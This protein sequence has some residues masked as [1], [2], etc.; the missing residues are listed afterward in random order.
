MSVQKVELGRALTAADP[1]PILSYRGVKH[2]LGTSGQQIEDSFHVPKPLALQELT[3]VVLRDR[4][5]L[6][7][8]RLTLACQR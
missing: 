7:Q 3:L 1:A 2:F 6:A 5:D 4:R 8:E